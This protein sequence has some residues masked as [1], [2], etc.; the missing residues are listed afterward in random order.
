MNGTTIFGMNI[1]VLA[2]VAAAVLIAVGAAISAA[3]CA[4]AR[5]RRARA[6]AAEDAEN[7]CALC[8]YARAADGDTV[9]CRFRGEVPADG[10]CR[11]FL[12]DPL[13]MKMRR[14]HFG[15]DEL[16]PLDGD[17]TEE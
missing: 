2:A 4:S 16:P 1:W 12:T 13:K 15:A 11:R 5:R 17:D 3:V 7:C 10:S 8:D 6:E 14:P 9:I